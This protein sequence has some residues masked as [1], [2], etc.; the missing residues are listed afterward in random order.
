LRQES[1]REENIM[2][3]FDNLISKLKNS[4]LLLVISF[5]LKLSATADASDIWQLP[6]IYRYELVKDAGEN[7][8]VVCDDC[9]ERKGLPLSFGQKIL[10]SLAVRASDNIT[11]K[12]CNC[13][14]A[15]SENREREEVRK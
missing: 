10:S 3:D 5:L 14:S 4:L 2:E 11:E 1:E 8:F 6:Y 7:A 15:Q 13:K 9:T 12:P